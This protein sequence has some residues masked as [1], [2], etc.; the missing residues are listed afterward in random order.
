MLAAHVEA[1]ALRPHIRLW[2]SDDADAVVTYGELDR[3]ARAIAH[4]LLMRG[5]G[6]GD[7]VAIM[8]PRDAAF[9][10]TFFG[11]L[12]AGAI[13]M[14]IYPRFRGNQVED[15]LRRQAGIL[16]NAEARVLITDEEIRRVGGLLKG[17]VESLEQVVTAAEL[18]RDGVL[19]SAV[20]ADRDTTALIQ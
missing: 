6:H 12:F 11:V 7:R 17:L 3:N 15:H 1:H 10:F 18:G 20:P 19:A 8:L 4:G 14:P 2:R 13:P 5:I 16:R 9:F